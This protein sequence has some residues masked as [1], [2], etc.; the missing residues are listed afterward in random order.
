MQQKLREGTHE[1]RKKFFPLI[2]QYFA[3]NNV[4]LMAKMDFCEVQ[5]NKKTDN[6]EEEEKVK[7][8]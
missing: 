5:W 1:K 3:G 7:L 2:L 4:K 8:L 6:E